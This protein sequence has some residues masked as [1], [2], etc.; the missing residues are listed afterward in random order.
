M[1][2][3]LKADSF[4]MVLIFHIVEQEFFLVMHSKAMTVYLEIFLFLFEIIIDRTS[5]LLSGDKGY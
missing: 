5:Y 1:E 4:N 3:F 2:I